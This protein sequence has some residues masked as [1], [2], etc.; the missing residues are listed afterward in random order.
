MAYSQ[1]GV[2]PKSHFDRRRNTMLSDHDKTY[3]VGGK[4][5]QA[6]IGTIDSASL[7]RLQCGLILPYYT[8]RGI[9]NQE[10]EN[11]TGPKN[12]EQK[13]PKSALGR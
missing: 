10:E 11:A 13:A 3:T 12:A 4:V 5:Q 7:V 6:R 9:K 2:L 1:H 8:V